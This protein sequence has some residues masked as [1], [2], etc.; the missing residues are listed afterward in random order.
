MPNIYTSCPMVCSPQFATVPCAQEVALHNPLAL[1]GA[2]QMG[3][4]GEMYGLV[5]HAW[6]TL[7]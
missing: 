1:S 5:A 3:N 2:Q 4:M 7:C 6:S